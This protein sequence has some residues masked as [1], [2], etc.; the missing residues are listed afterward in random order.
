MPTTAQIRELIDNTTSE[1]TE[2][3]DVNG[4]LFT[5]KNGNSIFIPAAGIA[6]DGSFDNSG[7]SGDVW[8]SM[9][10]TDIMYGVSGGQNLH[11]LSNN[12]YLLSG[13]RCYGFSVRGVL[14]VLG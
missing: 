12:V 8:S 6:L 2:Q 9:L 3:D 4:R 7:S 10:S 5:S 11:F 1:W 13:S 14:G